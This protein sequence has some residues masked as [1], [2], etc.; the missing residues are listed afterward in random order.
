MS[1]L[2]IAECLMA[3]L[4]AEL[5]HDLQGER[6]NIHQTKIHMYYKFQISTKILK[7]I[8]HAKGLAFT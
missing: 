1:Y 2:Q 6:N 4:R 7:H 5:V 3:Q 8:N